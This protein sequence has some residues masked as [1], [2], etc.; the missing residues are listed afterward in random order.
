[1]PTTEATAVRPSRSALAAV[2]RRTAPW[3]ALALLL[4]PAW[5]TASLPDNLTLSGYVRENPILWRPAPA[6]A[7]ADHLSVN[8]LHLRQNVRWYAAE[9]VT[10]ALEVKERL[11]LG[12]NARELAGLIAP[13]ESGLPY[14]DWTASADREGVYAEASIDRLWVEGTAGHLEVRAGRQRVA[15]GTNLVWNPID[16]FNPS[17]SLDF[18]NEEKPGTDAI[19]AQYYL[20]PA[21]EVDAAW[22]PGRE[23]ADTDAA[24]RVKVN[25]WGYDWMLVG[26]RRA[27]DHVAGF[28]WTGSVARGGFRGE[29]LLGRPRTGPDRTGRSYV[30]A[31]VSGAYTFP[32]T[33]YVQ[34]AALYESRGTTGDAGG[35]ELIEAAARQDL[36]PG[37]WAL[38]GEIAKDL[39][40]LWRA[41]LAA[42]VNP[43]DGSS[44][45]G[46]T[47][48]WSAAPSLDVVAAALLFNG[49][50]GAEFGGQGRIWMVRAKYSF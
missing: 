7:G 15:W 35:L 6:L 28:A 43:L 14:F 30:N 25:R 49:R 3:V 18:D 2:A 41:D 4:T 16:I 32:S 37:R 26:G 22:A 34:I 5:A 29:V 12:E 10:V 11:F 9:P 17:S 21:S 42:I 48:T 36:S 39:T 8:L 44:Y 13:A 45:L 27:N 33:L 46:P 24:A 23:A 20:G 38:F 19:R 47:L 31:S 40:P 50:T 1:L